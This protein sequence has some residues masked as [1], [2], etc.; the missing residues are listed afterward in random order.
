MTKTDS[1]FATARRALKSL[2]EPD[3]APALAP[4]TAIRLEGTM[5]VAASTSPR[6]ARQW[7][8]THLSL[9]LQG[10]GSFGAFT[11]GVLDR[12]LE[13]ERIELDMVSGASAGAINGALLASGLAVGGRAEARAVL[14]RFWRRASTAAPFIS[15]AKMAM[16]AQTGLGTFFRNLAPVQMNPFDLNPLRAMIET[17]VDFD[18]VRRSP[19]R[20][21]VSATRVRDGRL[22][23]FQNDE[24]DT[25][26]L[27]ASACLPQIHKTVWI[28]GEAYWD[29]GYVANPP[30]LH[31]VRDSGTDD[32]MVVRLTPTRIEDVP[33]SP[34][35]ITRRLDE[36]AFNS[37][38]ESEIAALEAITW[39][40]RNEWSEDTPSLRRL[41]ALRLHT[42]AAE[43]SVE[44]LGK[45]SASDLDLAFLT[46]LRDAGR[47]ATQ[48]WIDA[49]E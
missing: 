10:G 32:V 34:R 6:R 41:R 23:I 9:A 37:P 8:P 45:Q 20:L 39:R 38:L 12:L 43:D 17:E 36:I 30:L 15:L 29:G 24:L 35:A 42:I 11:W 31:L 33:T 48:D 49:G 13:D 47:A 25:D 18:A 16:P 19:L 1:L 40:S 22:R 21:M 28:D 14:E 7:P 27:L 2:L 44:G 46:R 4:S 5:R 3:P 26:R